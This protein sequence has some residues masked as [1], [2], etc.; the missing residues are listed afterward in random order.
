VALPDIRDTA[1]VRVFPALRKLGER[2]RPRDIPVVQQV[3]AT[4]C[5][6]AC[7]AMV[8]GHLGHEVA[9]DDV[10]TAMGVGRDGVSARVIL[11]TAAFYQL[12]GRGV[13]IDLEDLAHLPKGA[14]LHWNLSH[15]VV[16]ERMEGTTAVRVIDPAFGRRV[17]PLDEAA[18]C[19]TGV[20]L[21]LE[22]SD[23]FVPAKTGDNPIVRHLRN[24][25][26]GSDDW[27][28]I[29][30][31]SVFLQLLTLILPMVQGRLIDRVVPRNDTHLLFVLLA[32]LGT[33]LVFHFL[34][35]MTRAQL[36]LHLR[37]RFDAKMTFG[38]IGHLLR[39]PYAFFERR[40]I[41]DLQM[42]V[43]T[44]AS[45][46]DALTG[47][48]LSGLIDGA[49]VLGH[50]AFLLMMSVKVTLLALAVV[51]VQAGIYL[52]TR[53]KLHE[54]AAG[55]LAKQADAANALNELLAGIESLKASGCEQRA[56][57][58]WAARYVD[59]MNVGLRQGHLMTFSQSVLGTLQV[60]GPM[61]LLIGG[62]LEV[63]DGRMTLGM[64]MSANAL[65]VGFLQ[66]T[67]NL[68]SSL[69]TLQLI[70]AQLG[71]LDDVRQAETEQRPGAARIAPRLRGAIVL[72]RVSFRYSRRQRWAVRDVSVSIAAGESV[73]IVGRSG[74]GK[75]T[76]GRLLAGLYQP[77]EG[78]VLFD[79]I[80]L[81]ELDLGSVRRQLG[82]VVQ[83]PHI[84]GTTIRANIALANPD[85]PLDRVRMAA[86]RACLHD[87]VTRMPMEYDTPVVAGGASLSGGQRQRLAL[88]RAL[89]QEPAILLLDE[90][91]SALDAIT[92]V[93]VQAELN[94]LRCTRVFIAH[95][96]S[97][98]INADRI[99][100]MDN[101]QLVEH[102][103]HD[104]L[105][106]RG[107]VYARL[108]VA[109]LAEDRSLVPGLAGDAAH[110]A[111]RRVSVGQTAR[112]DPPAAL[113]AACCA[114]ADE[115]ETAAYPP[116]LVVHVPNLAR[117]HRPSGERR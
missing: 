94:L 35:A 85:L 64:M 40:Q 93:A 116:T 73:A 81:G 98:V 15:F 66:P 114:A 101:G 110:A 59:V 82:V 55:S 37:T 39:L 109:Q 95:R 100:V 105:L 33:I 14:I 32:G 52:A 56:S 97:T 61:A 3:T 5:G 26:A 30:F 70:R 80:P 27:H 24:A 63:M 102:G 8:L 57:D 84:F 9:L 23:D 31:V 77:E 45:I 47:A 79:G 112:L 38:F 42:R 4:D 107:G 1:L 86:A 90:A 71:R 43:S 17:V 18:R 68:V 16:F 50:L 6:A 54:L 7:L 10:R 115:R 48:V 78:T 88:A 67:M 41:G 117:G 53:R 104:E 113:L 83:R 111:A 44:V 92:E 34:G 91:T 13:R 20:A 99:L 60:L 51:G 106:A 36:L 89:V 11:E 69:Q 103:T 58:V 74:S 62:V 75:T 87:D 25:F 22:R 21:L 12:R 96:L 46:R 28:R 29:V 19:F 108:V 76:L 65:A 49:M 72:D 2:L